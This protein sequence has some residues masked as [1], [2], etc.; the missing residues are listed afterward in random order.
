VGTARD[1]DSKENE[2]CTFSK[3]MTMYTIR[4]EAALYEKRQN[5]K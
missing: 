4:K 3:K 2:K 1:K 5:T